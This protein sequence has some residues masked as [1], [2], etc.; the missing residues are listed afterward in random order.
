MLD[1]QTRRELLTKARQSGFPGSILDVFTAYE[2]GKDLIG[3]FQQQQQQQQSQ[4][5]SNMA[6]QQAG[7]MA[8]GQQPLPQEMP[9][10]PAG[11]PPGL[12]GQSLPSSEPPAN[13]NLVDSTQQ[14]PVGMA[15]NAKGSSGGQ[16]IMANG[17]FVEKFTEDQ[18]NKFSTHFPFS[19]EQRGSIAH[20]ATVENPDLTMVRPKKYVFGGLK[21]AVGGFEVTH[22][23]EQM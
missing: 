2:Q 21:Y 8:P 16:V 17:G 5:M 1:N 3:E 13:P 7:M 19:K 22:L 9:Q 12:Q 6:A 4:Q 11:P 18:Y 10:A 23:E 14:Q 20:N 15:T